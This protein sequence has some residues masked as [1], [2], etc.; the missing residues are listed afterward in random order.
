MDK[1]NEEKNDGVSTSSSLRLERS[2]MEIDGVRD[3]MKISH[4][5][6]TLNLLDVRKFKKYVTEIEPGIDFN[7]TARIQGGESVSC[8]LRL[9]RSFWNPE[10]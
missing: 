6:K 9:G 7:T 8:F 2:I 3:K 10:I 5:L 4:I 1:E